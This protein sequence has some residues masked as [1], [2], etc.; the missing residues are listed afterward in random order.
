MLIVL[1]FFH[2]FSY[3]KD[4]TIHI[5]LFHCLIYVGH[6]FYSNFNLY[7]IWFPFVHFSL[8][9]IFSYIFAPHTPCRLCSPSPLGSFHI[10]LHFPNSLVLSIC[11]LLTTVSPFCIFSS[12]LLRDVKC[13]T[14]RSRG[15][16]YPQVVDFFSLILFWWTG[17]IWL[18]IISVETLVFPLQTMCMLRVLMNCRIETP[19]TCGAGHCGRR[20]S[21]PTDAW[22]GRQREFKMAQ[23]IRQPFSSTHK[24]TICCWLPPLIWYDWVLNDLTLFQ[25]TD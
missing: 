10:C 23:Q 13:L 24:D 11:F 21:L 22:G 3:L 20:L 1:F 9:Y 8:M 4:S 12:S 14:C 25:V 18:Q 7:Y 19:G 17:E 5:V 15:L 2:C 16:I 6:F